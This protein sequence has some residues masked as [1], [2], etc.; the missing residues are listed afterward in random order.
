MAADQ[1]K[2]PFAR[3]DSADNPSIYSP[4]S[5]ARR[6]N[7]GDPENLWSGMSTGIQITAYLLAGL[8]AYGGVGWLIDWLAGTG[9]VFTAIGMVV[10]AVFGI[11]LVYVRYGKD[12]G[13]NR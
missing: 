12:D 6:P 10:G 5:M 8:F 3:F 4:R 7:P 1:H 2:H 11:Y 13:T 9:K